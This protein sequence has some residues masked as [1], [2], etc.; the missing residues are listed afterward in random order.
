MF[1]FFN[2]RQTSSLLVQFMVEAKLPFRI[3]TKPAC[4]NDELLCENLGETF[5]EN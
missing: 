4:E 2:Q 5:S 1:P 3:F